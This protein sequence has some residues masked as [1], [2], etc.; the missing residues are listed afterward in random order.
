MKIKI[1]I[2]TYNNNNA[3]NNT[4]DSLFTTITDN[5]N[6]FIYLINNHSNLYIN[7]D[8]S[9]KIHII[10]NSVR[11]DF[12]TGH[13]ARD[14]NCAIINGFQDLNNPNC[15]ILVTCQNDSVFSPSWLD[16]LILWHEKYSFISACPGDGFCSYTVDS[17]KNV[18]L[19][20][21]RFNSIEFQ[22][23]DYFNRQKIFNRN[24]ASINDFHHNRVLNKIL[25]NEEDR[26]FVSRS[27][28]TDYKIHDISHTNHDY[29]F[30]LL[31]SKY[32][33]PLD[34]YNFNSYNNKQTILYPYFE[35]N[36]LDLS[37]KYETYGYVYVK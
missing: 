11:P 10:H 21:E 18:G 33:F 1:Y 7:N 14:W 2:V 32:R 26:S 13:L 3:L 34:Y 6:I 17:V 4:L 37:S 36:I 23:A 8:Y 20:D 22:E 5:H 27:F 9:N 28:L 24:N 25:L 35:K 31:N 16:K 12:S 29:N 15:D 30:T 19:W